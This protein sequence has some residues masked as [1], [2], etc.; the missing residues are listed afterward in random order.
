MLTHDLPF[1]LLGLDH[2]VLRMRDLAGLERFYCAIV[3]R[4]VERRRPELRLLHLRGGR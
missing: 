2:V 1:A 4:A 3:G